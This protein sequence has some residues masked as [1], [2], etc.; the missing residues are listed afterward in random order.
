[1]LSPTN[2]IKQNVSDAWTRLRHALPALAALSRGEE[3]G[4]GPVFL[5]QVDDL[6]EWL[7]KTI[8]WHKDEISLAQ[9]HVESK[10]R[11]WTASDGHYASELH[12][13][14]TTTGLQVLLVHVA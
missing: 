1:M 8:I 12:V 14:S 6:K 4:S 5:Y 2:N 7:D 11:A 13:S 10:K 9:R 3:D